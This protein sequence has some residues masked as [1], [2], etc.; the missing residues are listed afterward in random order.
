[1]SSL[2]LKNIKQL[3]SV[4]AGDQPLYG[5]EMAIVPGIDDAWLLVEGNEIAA[6]GTMDSLEKNL[7]K[8]PGEQMDCRGRLV[9]PAWCDSHTHLVF[10]GS[11]EHEFVDKI[12][13]LHYA[14]INARGGGIL[15]TVQKIND[16]PEDELFRLSWNRLEEIARLGTGAVEIKSGYG[17]S[18]ESELKML[19]VIRKLKEKSSLQIRSTFLG[20]HTYPLAYRGRHETYIREIIEDMLP[21][22]AGEKLADYIDVFCEEGFFSLQE[23]GSILRAGQQHGLAVK[24]HVNQL[25]SIGGIDLGVKL[26]ALSMDHLETMTAADI[27]L[28]RESGWK[29]LC[30]LLPT[31]AFFLRMAF[32]PARQLM[33]SGCAVALASDYNPGTSP[34]GNMNTVIAL[35]CI[36]MKLLPEEALNAA[37][38]NGAFAMGLG[39]SCGSISPGRLANLIITVP[40]PSLAFL[41]YSFGS[42]LIDKVIIRGAF[43]S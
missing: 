18:V 32:P 42:N 26:N 20:A 37:T 34:S 29:G 9:L 5:S 40:V 21:I 4:R 6:F 19:R 35:A 33:E 24:M 15:S 22:I 8:Q 7:P 38:I 11:R 31:A 16:I 43:I 25:N 2:L 1:M 14:D 36:Q 27:D 3:L 28:L 10:A 30:T 41:P 17:L 39:N 23:S 12:K 13:G